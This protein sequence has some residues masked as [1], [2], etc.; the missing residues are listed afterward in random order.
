MIITPK[1]RSWDNFIFHCALQHIHEYTH[2]EAIHH[3]HCWAY[4]RPLWFHIS[5]Y[6]IAQRR[7]GFDVGWIIAGYLH[8]II[9]YLMSNEQL[10]ELI[11]FIT[12]DLNCSYWLK[13]MICV[14]SMPILNAHAYED[15]LFLSGGQTTNSLL[16][17][18]FC[19]HSIGD[20]LLKLVQYINHN[21]LTQ[22]FSIRESVLFG[23]FVKSMLKGGATIL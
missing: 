11:T 18:N 7:G 19:K 22:D 3:S 6:N 21:S 8:E 5:D 16:L 2:S 1:A 15:F 13:L 10:I 14:Y 4:S 9:N 23:L 20:L 17:V 12:F